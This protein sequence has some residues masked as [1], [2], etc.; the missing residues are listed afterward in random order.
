[1][2][3]LEFEVRGE[4]ESCSSEY[5]LQSDILSRSGVRLTCFFRV[6]CFLSFSRGISD[7]YYSSGNSPSLGI[8]LRPSLFGEP[9]SDFL[10][11]TGEILFTQVPR[12]AFSV[13]SFIPEESVT[14]IIAQY[15]K[16]RR[17]SGLGRND[18]SQII[19][20]R[21]MIFSLLGKVRNFSD[22]SARLYANHRTQ[23]DELY[24]RLALQN[25]PS[26]ITLFEV[27]EEIF[28]GKYGDQELYATHLAL[29]GDGAKFQTDKA[30]H[31]ATSTF[32]VRSK[33]DVAMI[34]FAAR[35]V[36][37]STSKEDV[38]K[39]RQNLEL[40]RGQGKKAQLDKFVDKA[41][42]LID[43][44]RKYKKED[45][46]AKK[47][48]EMP[49]RRVR[50]EEVVWE[51]SD[52]FFIDF[53]KASVLQHGVQS[54][55]MDSLVPSILRAMD[56]YTG[57]LNGVIG[58]QFLTEIGAWGAW[59]NL[60]LRQQNITFPGY[61]TSSV[62]DEDQEKV[63]GIDTLAAIKEMGLEDCMK[64]LRKDW[65]QLEVYCIDDAT[66]HEIDDG[67]SLE[68]VSETENW[69]HVHIANP[70][71]FLPQNHW[72]SDVAF[73]RK[74]SLYLPE[75]VYPM[76][77][78]SLTNLVGMGPDRGVMTISAKINKD[79]EL[80][81]FNVQVGFV[82]NVKRF[83][84]DAISAALGE[85][86]EVAITYRVGEFPQ[87]SKRPETVFTKKQLADLR[88][89]SEIAAARRQQ[90]VKENMVECRAPSYD[91]T[92]ND[93][94]SSPIHPTGTS[95][96][97]LYRGH[98][99]IRLTVKPER[100]DGISH[101]MVSEIMQLANDATARFC[102]KNNIAAPF[103]V[104]EYDIYRSDMV[105]HFKENILP[106]RDNLGC[107]DFELGLRYM[108]FLGPTRLSSS[109]K[110]HRLMGLEHGYVRATS[111]LRRYSDM[112]AHWQIQTYLLG[113]K[114]R[115]HKQLQNIIPEMDRGERLANFTTKDSKRFWGTVAV[116]RILEKDK[117]KLPGVM[118]FMVMEKSRFPTPSVG[119]VTDLGMVGKVEF[120]DR[121]EEMSV[122]VGDILKVTPNIAKA[123]EK[124]VWYDFQAVARRGLAML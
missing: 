62:V 67:I 94:L 75:K 20:P 102:G 13:P 85:P 47:G 59:E 105:N 40:E 18:L 120:K 36:R 46:L 99:S 80:L 90:R 71:A 115:T 73:R 98:P 5:R 45:M 77:P 3:F 34:D 100:K 79:G 61:G 60:A 12:I 123:G 30:T 25:S 32:T 15:D 107:I 8:Y 39:K 52:M 37:K 70:T 43:L 104:M 28:G 88:T 44:S 55:P 110:P 89:L 31:R 121:R 54:T 103:R 81:D 64:E 106:S 92:V 19:L 22:E 83:T 53:V 72:L 124:F 82:R 66:A 57:E 16:I 68:R 97:F 74:Q 51:K 114:P 21:Q 7:L 86:G 117:T 49:V 33:A 1:M 17:A 101:F 63:A 122:L 91:V 58:Y 112:I 118:E 10:M 108:S 113:K 38:V 6:I 42:C 14:E 116:G 48:N 50:V 29:M 109:P 27:V 87:P 35:N 119:L 24:E 69:V 111:P 11:M 23:F 95:Q 9:T 26:T 41:R 96:P 93:G 2:S 56:R 78:V 65:D 84:Y 76:L 4:S